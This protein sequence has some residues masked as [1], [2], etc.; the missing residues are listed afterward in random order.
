MEVRR[1]F[2]DDWQANRAIRL[3]ALT[4]CPGNYFTSLA[5]AQARSDDQWRGMLMSATLVV[6]GLFD[7]EQLAG[8]TAI[9]RE[10]D[11]TAT[12]AMSYIRPAWRRRGY[13]GLLYKAR[14]DWAREHKVRR[15]LVSH[16][17]SNA[18]S[19]HAIARHGF[20]PTGTRPHRWPDGTVEDD[21]GYELIMEPHR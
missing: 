12:L 2:V 20:L 18:P 15:I 6:F 4:E 11:D 3:E 10:C 19:R 1:L 13:S 14:L 9:G 7:G 21:V 8:I 5:E 17:A 16:R